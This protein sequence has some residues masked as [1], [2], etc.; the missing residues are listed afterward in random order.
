[1]S[2]RAP[3]GQAA[4]VIDDIEPQ[5]S[6]FCGDGVCCWRLLFVTD[7]S[8]WTC[9]GL[10]IVEGQPFGVRRVTQALMQLRIIKPTFGRPRLRLVVRVVRGVSARRRGWGARSGVKGSRVERHSGLL[11]NAND[12]PDE[13]TDRYR[14]DQAWTVPREGRECMPYRRVQCGSPEEGLLL[15]V[16]APNANVPGHW[17]RTM[18]EIVRDPFRISRGSGVAECLDYRLEAEPPGD[19]ILIIAL[20]LHRLAV[21]HRGHNRDGSGLNTAHPTSITIAA[22]TLMRRR[23]LRSYVP[24]TVRGDDALARSILCSFAL[25]C[26]EWPRGRPPT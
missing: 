22:N 9:I 10:V 2:H 7:R 24:A 20:Q 15:A 19:V 6:F 12:L 5:F 3:G 4:G 25:R 16:I 17:W 8:P 14:K 18:L 26:S 13:V 1:M 11:L 23:V 21:N